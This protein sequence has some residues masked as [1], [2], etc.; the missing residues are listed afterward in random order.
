MKLTTEQLD[1]L[2]QRLPQWT[3]TRQR[4]GTLQRSFTFADFAQAFGFMAQV[5]VHAERMNHHPEWSNVYHRV[6]VV[7]TTHDIEGIS[8][9]DIDMALLMDRISAG[10]AAP[11]P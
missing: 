1:A 7:L 9:N 8:Q 4:G 3:Q 2:L 10:L 11:T 5:A 6:D